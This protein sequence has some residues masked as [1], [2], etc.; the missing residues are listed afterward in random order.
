M[1]T[2]FS[3]NAFGQVTEETSPD[4]GTIRYEYDAAG[5]LAAIV[6]GRGQ[7]VQYVRDILGRIVSKTPVSR[8]ASERVTYT[9]DAPAITGSY[10]VGRLSRI[11]DGT[12]ATRF[13]YDH[14]GNMVT[15]QQ[16]LVGT[17]DWA[18][19]RYAYDLA[20][21]V[22]TITYPSGRQVRYV[23]DAK[24]RVVSVRT[25]ASNT[26]ATWTTISSSMS[27]EAF[28][29]LKTMSLGNG[30]RM[31]VTYGDDGRLD[32]RRLYR[33]ADGVNIS[34]LT[35]GYDADDNM[36]RITDRL[37]ADNTQTFAYDE[38]DRL[39]RVTTATGDIRRTDYVFDANGN[40]TRELR[41]PLPTDPPSVATVDRYALQAGTNR[42]AQ[43]TTP[44]GTRNYTHDARG[45][46][47]TETRPGGVT[48]SAGYDGQ[49][50]LVSYSRS[51][52]AGLAHVYNGLDDRVATTRGSSTRRFVYAPDGRV[53]GEYGNNASD[54]KAEFIWMSPQVGEAAMF[55][56][57]DGL[58]GYMPLAV[59]VPDSATPGTTQLAWVHASHMG[60]PI[61]YSD[62]GGNTLMPPTDYSVPG[63]PGQSKT[64]AD[65]YYNRYRDYDPTTGRYV[66]AD[67]IGLAGGASPY[68]Y[69]MNNPLRYTD[70]DGR[71]VPLALC[72]IGAIAGGVGTALGEGLAGQGFNLKL[73]AIGAGVGCVAGVAAPFA[74]TTATGALILGAA[75]N[76]GQYAATQYADGDCI[77]LGGLA[78]NA[79][80][81]AIA[82]KLL[83]PFTPRGLE[84]TVDPSMSA[85]T[86]ALHRSL[87][88]Q[89]IIDVARRGFGNSIGSGAA[90][91]ISGNPSLWQKASDF[92]DRIF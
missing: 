38:V 24:G 19:L 43:V 14:R 50:R 48:V 92:W 3:R 64:M 87:N 10:A 63:F 13:A 42:L 75:T 65:L 36:V 37:N 33:V 28:G 76:A 15:R 83:G 52:E 1:T 56:G 44:A 45:N 62:A 79:G 29:A 20:D 66:Q 16:K 23:R 11:D 74:A 80:L 67:P 81:G 18:A 70:P 84:S 72:G 9:W 49:G 35:Y 5:D 40:R 8:P 71:I 21:R 34:H 22:E 6:D 90:T 7:R 59:A 17:P 2:R 85:A 32:G 27:Y 57:D 4:R 55:G 82:G 69:A 86:Q 77:T 89:R 68:S 47:L 73:V 54:V 51:G 39:K 78:F 26:V 61:R 88:E 31:I 30:E 46:M 58:G 91:T 41:R 25:R 53:L 60:V 12:G